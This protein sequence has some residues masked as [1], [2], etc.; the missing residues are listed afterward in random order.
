MQGLL[1]PVQGMLCLAQ[2]LLQGVL[3]GIELLHLVH[4]AVLRGVPAQLHVGSVCAVFKAG[5]CLLCGPDLVPYGLLDASDVVFKLCNLIFRILL[6]P[7]ELILG[8]LKLMYPLPECVL[9][10]LVMEAQL[11]YTN[12][13]LIEKM[14]NFELATN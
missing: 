8:T 10:G 9:R 11:I 4:Q 12:V 3:A 1:E 2:L 14:R 13:L 7:F 5:L 6:L